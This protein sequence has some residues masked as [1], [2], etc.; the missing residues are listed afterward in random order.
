[1]TENLKSGFAGFWSQNVDL[2]VAAS[3]VAL[4]ALIGAAGNRD[5]KD[6]LAARKEHKQKTLIE[7]AEQTLDTDVESEVDPD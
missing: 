2:I 6:V 3:M 5:I 7:E 1:M 4:G